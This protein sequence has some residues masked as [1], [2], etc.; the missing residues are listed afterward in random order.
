MAQVGLSPDPQPDTPSQHANNAPGGGA[1]GRPAISYWLFGLTAMT[2]VFASLL[3]LGLLMRSGVI[4]P[5]IR[6]AVTA[7]GALIAGIGLVA[8][9]YV[10]AMGRRHGIFRSRG[11]ERHAV[12]TLRMGGG[13]TFVPTVPPHS[14]R[15]LV[16]GREARS[17]QAHAIAIAAAP[18]MPLPHTSA[19][20]RYTSVAPP[21]VDLGDTAR[22]TTPTGPPALATPWI[23]P[24]RPA[25]PT[26]EPVPTS[27]PTARPAAPIV[28]PWI[29]PTR[30][31][32][33]AASPATRERP[34]QV[35]PEPSSESSTWPSVKP[36][37]QASDAPSR[38]P[39]NAMPPEFRLTTP[40]VMPRTEAAAL[41][42][43]SASLRS[44]LWEQEVDP[45]VAD[46]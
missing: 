3:L 45:N 30:S 25:T 10:L 43:R 8:A 12:R 37:S 15:E 4:D 32:A 1:K 42:V 24:A 35:M 28:T 9:A 6:A 17:R 19:A 2:L 14:Q 46:R 38:S 13:L 21:R 22:S 26:Y 16:Q 20:P 34:A 18:L 44:L 7:Y 41:Q 31:T 33:P 29:P 27:W 40:P 23:P 5:T 39:T 11:R 36:R